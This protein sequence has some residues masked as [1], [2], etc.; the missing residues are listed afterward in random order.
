M[1]QE[2]SKTKYFQQASS[3]SSIAV[4]STLQL[5]SKFGYSC[6]QVGFLV[7]AQLTALHSTE[8][9]LHGNGLSSSLG[10]QVAH[11][12]LPVSESEFCIFAVYSLLIL[13]Y[14]F[15]ESSFLLGPHVVGHH[16][17]NTVV[18]ELLVSASPRQKG[19]GINGCA[20]KH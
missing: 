1:Q 11:S 13:L 14:K 20:K 9:A 10:V 3:L 12:H 6:Y 7:I 18:T 4:P 15:D 19:H 8:L 17:I 5:A 2:Q 16:Q